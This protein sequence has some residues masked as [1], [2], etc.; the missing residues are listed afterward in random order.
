VSARPRHGGGSP[1]FPRRHDASRTT[2]RSQP[3]AGRGVTPGGPAARTRRAGAIRSPRARTLPAWISGT[4][5][6]WVRPCSLR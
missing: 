1:L 5:S 2:C 3:R 4:S 6:R